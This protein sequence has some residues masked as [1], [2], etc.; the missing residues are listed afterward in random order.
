LQRAVALDPRSLSARL[1]LALYWQRQG[2][3]GRALET[4]QAAA[5]L[6]PDSPAVQIELG[7]IQAVLGD[8]EA[9]RRAFQRAIDLAPDDPASWRALAGFALT[10]E[11]ELRSLGLPAAR[12]AVLLAP[13]DPASLDLMAVVL[14]RLNDQVGA[15]RFLQRALQ[16]QADYAPAHLHLGWL[17]LLQEQTRRAYLAFDQAVSIDRTSVAGRQAQQALETYFP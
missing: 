5:R 3:P 8:L 6:I 15:E 2:R 12:R 13:Q 11:Y 9:A 14:L 10:N 16:V 7:N 17:Y 1:F 4:L